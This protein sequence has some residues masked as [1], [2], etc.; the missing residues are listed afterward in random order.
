MNGV[1]INGKTAMRAR[2]PRRIARTSTRS[3]FVSAVV[4][5]T[6]M[7]TN[8]FEIRISKS[9]TNSK[10]ECSKDYSYLR[11]IDPKIFINSVLSLIR[12]VRSFSNSGLLLTS[13]NPNQYLPSFASFRRLAGAVKVALPV[14]D[15]AGRVDLAGRPHF[16]M[17]HVRA[18]MAIYL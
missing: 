2:R 7:I 12:V 16:R 15:G 8:K 17:K 13:I 4:V 5:C 3:N 10:L 14:Q 18:Y 1:T 11:T 9:E 6:G